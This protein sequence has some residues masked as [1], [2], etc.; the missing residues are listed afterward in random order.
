MPEIGLQVGVDRFDDPVLGILFGE[1]GRLARRRREILAVGVSFQNLSRG[2][3]PGVRIQVD[4][5]AER[6]HRLLGLVVYAV[7]NTQPL[8]QE[9]PVG[10]VARRS[11]LLGHRAQHFPQGANRIRRF[12]FRLQQRNLVELH[13]EVGRIEFAGFVR[14]LVRLRKIALLPVNLRDF[15]CRAQMAGLLGGDLQENLQRLVVVSGLEQ[16]LGIRGLE[17]GIVPVQFECPAIGFRGALVVLHLVVGNGQCRQR[18]QAGAFLGNPLQQQAGVRVVAQVPVY[19]RQTGQRFFTIRIE[20]ESLLICLLGSRGVGR[21]FLQPAEHQPVFE[22]VRSLLADLLVLLDGRAQHLLIHPLLL[23]L[24]D[25]GG[26]EPG[27]NPARVQVV[28]VPLQHILEL[29]DRNPRLARLQIQVG[30]FLREVRRGGVFAHRQFVILDRLAEILA[31]P[32]VCRR[33]FRVHVPQR[34]VVVSRRPAVGLCGFVR[35]SEK[36]SAAS[37]GAGRGGQGQIAQKTRHC[38]CRPCFTRTPRRP[39]RLERRA[40]IQLL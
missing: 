7:Q 9:C 12:A 28:G 35:L 40:P 15:Q 33:Q 36:Q 17:I 14:I 22:I 18:P 5:L 19:H 38:Q 25:P 26:V 34:G 23:A 4:D 10:P 30:Q 8:Q 13:F 16:L 6:R 31:A 39:G 3:R 1:H 2:A 37:R 20:F 29:G 24:A 27:Q 11:Q 21:Q 32:A